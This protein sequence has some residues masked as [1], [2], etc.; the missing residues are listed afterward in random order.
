M[1]ISALYYYNGKKYNTDKQPL[2]FQA[3]LDSVS[4]SPVAFAGY[5]EYQ[6]S[7]VYTG[8]SFEKYGT[9]IGITSTGGDHF[10]YSAD[11]TTGSLTVGK[12][13]V[14]AAYQTTSQSPTIQS[15]G[16][17]FA[18]IS[19]PIGYYAGQHTLSYNANGGTGAPTTP[20]TSY[21]ASN[22]SLTRYYYNSISSTTPTRTGYNFLGWATSSSATTASYQPGDTNVTV[23]GSTLYAVWQRTYTLNFNANGGTGTM[24]AQT[25]N[26]N[27]ATINSNTFTRDGYIFN[28][29]N[30]ASGG[31]GTSYSDGGTFTVPA[32]GTST[33]L[34]AQ[35]EPL[36]PEPRK[37][38]MYGPAN[39]EAIS[40]S[41]SYGPARRI[42]SAT[43]EYTPGVYV[44]SIDNAQLVKGLNS[45]SW[46]SNLIY[47]GEDVTG[48]R[49]THYADWTPDR[50]TIE[51][52]TTTRFG[53]LFDGPYDIIA[54][55]AASIY[56]ITLNQV[57]ASVG[58]AENIGITG[59]YGSA[60]SR[61]SKLYG[62]ANGQAKR[63]F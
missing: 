13:Y 6:S 50:W 8:K 15:A 18:H 5:V 59:V 19:D 56:G 42:L 20:E 61:I 4:Y 55:I 47:E 26:G 25:I 12:R 34:F 2:V 16:T 44:S 39:D 45:Y 35:W 52:F 38:S 3:R 49:I 41:K 46:I 24:A 48:F 36:P 58:G 30:T 11:Y 17:D 14:S 29:W 60:T 22:S 28:G 63:I 32:S 37:S 7:A 57:A 31:S 54:P 1:S 21:W 43:T 10:L 62:S 23:T 40:V 53:T 33:T 9:V 27:S 51:C